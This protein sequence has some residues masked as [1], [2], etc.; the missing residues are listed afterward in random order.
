MN[1]SMGE[2]FTM[3]KVFA[4]VLF[5]LLVYLLTKLI[6]EKNTNS[7]SMVNILGYEIG[8]ISRL[9]LIASIWVVFVSA[10]VAMGV[11]TWFFGYILRI[12]MKGYGGWFTLNI[13]T[14]IY[15]E[16]FLLLIGT[17]LVVAILEYVKIKK[18]PME[19]A[20]K[21]VE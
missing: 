14:K 9:Y 18:I 13:S 11:N 1:I 16:M 5:A 7:I 6:L 3:V 2:M 10:I 8:E 21:N 12:F 17:Y 15:L 19:E 20:L 4:I